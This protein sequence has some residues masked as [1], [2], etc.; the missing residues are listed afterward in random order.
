MKISYN[1]LKQFIKTNKTSEEISVLL[2]DLGLE[3]EGIEQFESVKGGLKGVV[4]GLVL[5]CEKHP[6]AD[7]LK[8]T[9][10]DIGEEKP[11]QIV[12][13]APNVA[14]G[15]KVAVAT[16]GTTLYDKEGNAFQ[17]KKGKIRGEDSF[18]MICSEDELGLGTSS[19][20]ILVLDDKTKIGTP[21]S[22]IFDIES[23]E[24][25]E[26]GLTPNRADA[27]SHWGVARDIKAGLQQAES[28]HSELITP[29]ISSFRVD[30]RTLKIDVDVIDAKLCP[31]YCGITI[32]GVTVKESPEWLKNRLKAI[33]LTPKNN[34]VDVTNYVL[35]ELGQPL[36]A[37]DASKI[38]GN[39]IIVKTA[40]EGTK[41]ITLDE[42][43][44]TLSAED[45]MIYND[46]VPMA[47]AGVM[48]GKNSAV[49]ESTS[50]IFLE[51]AYFDAITVRKSAKRHAI[52]SDASF[53]F[54]RGIDPTITEYALKRAAI[55]IKE[56]AGGEITS[57][58][59]D[60]YPKKIEGHQVF[61]NF[62][63]LNKIVGQTIPQE[64]IKNILTSLEIKIGSISDVGLGLT[65]PPYRVDVQ[66]E[67]DVV[68]DILRV[69]GY[70]NIDFSGKL[71]ASVAYSSRTEEYKLQ[72]IIAELL[73][74]NGF[75]EIMS[76]SL[77]TP[78]YVKLSEQLSEEQNVT[79][80]NP[81][82]SDLSVMRQSLLFNGLEAVSYNINRKNADLKLYEF[83]NIYRK[84]AGNYTENKHLAIF[85]TGDRNA[86]SWIEKSKKSDFFLLKSYIMLV[87][88]RLGIKGVRTAT[89]TDDVFSEGI[90][91]VRGNEVLAEL[92]II[93]KNI[94]KHF[95]IKHEVLYA[96]V[97]WGSIIKLVTDKIKFTEIAKYPEVRRDLALLLD[98]NVTFED[99]YQIAEQTDKKLVKEIDLFDVYQGDKLPQGKKSY[100]VSFIIQDQEKTLTEDQIEK[101]MSKIVTNLTEKL[102]AILR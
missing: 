90:S 45:L 13:G 92:G 48:G 61:L 54:E 51:S 1:W 85:I 26:I 3:V 82:S 68:E 29:S 101:T 50:N 53:R 49:S 12:C 67:I 99:I 14:Q 81:L 100:A 21:V 16:I 96:D 97:K 86:E 95:D 41:F 70:N 39:K 47:I 91:L 80:L 2:T 31:R 35:H 46:E 28:V 20:G 69:Y 79:I 15:Q 30:K 84:Q 89:L 43:E 78:E 57:D 5:T 58:T 42:V 38:K 93:K 11:L 56:L 36:H 37:F 22:K 9:T 44:R 74:S 75:N 40:V 18:G 77:T 72:N 63:T 17:I 34:I 60:L 19:D 24:V 25:F 76:N 73:T 66:R 52:N 7:K 87:F 6:N 27:M 59:T 32:S 71:S 83:G 55:L 33:G 94:L 98:E 102:G 8:I 65:I 88:N 4:V 62:E 23:D 64:T 10:V